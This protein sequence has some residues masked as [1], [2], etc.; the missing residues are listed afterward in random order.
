MRPWFALGLLLLA[1][2]VGPADPIA[3]DEGPIEPIH[4][5]PAKPAPAA[6]S[7]G[8]AE[9][10]PEPW[11]KT[12]HDEGRITCAASGTLVT[13]NACSGLG[14]VLDDKFAWVH[15]PVLTPEWIQVELVYDWQAPTPGG[16]RVGL[17][18]GNEATLAAVAEGASPIVLGIG[19][20]AIESHGMASS[21]RVI[22][23]PADD[24]NLVLDQDFDVYVT[25]FY[26]EGPSQGWTYVNDG[27]A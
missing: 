7:N 9:P 3:P 27:E 14:A 11:A 18:G 5:A 16:L 15:E 22:V 25:V 23:I 26:H 6:S 19:R 10:A 1:G 4:Q 21:F 24:V 8:S 20:E 12:T 17:S 13:I 2:C